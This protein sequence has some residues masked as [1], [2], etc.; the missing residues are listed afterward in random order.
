M[1]NA[2]DQTVQSADRA[3]AAGTS[4]EAIVESMEYAAR[5]LESI[6]QATVEQ[7]RSSQQTNE[8]LSAIREVALA[9]SSHMEIFTS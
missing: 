5:Q 6:A 2:A 3:S 4:M 1:D 9:T 7:S 8:A